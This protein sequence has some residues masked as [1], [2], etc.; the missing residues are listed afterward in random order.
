MTLTIDGLNLTM[1]GRA[2]VDLVRKIYN[3]VAK[4]A[5]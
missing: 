1:E 3:R 5:S 4:L 2:K